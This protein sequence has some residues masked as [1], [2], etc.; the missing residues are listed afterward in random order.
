MTNKN[1]RKV[2]SLGIFI[3]AIFVLGRAVVLAF[4]APQFNP[5]DGSGALT[6]GTGVNAGNIGIGAASP[7]AK[8]HVSAPAGTDAFSIT[9][10]LPLI[11][12]Q[13]R[14]PIII[15]NTGGALVN[16]QVLLTIDTASLFAVGKMKFSDC[17]DLRVTSA[18]GVT[19]QNYWIESGC[20]TASTKIWAK[21]LAI[22]AGNS[23]IYLYYGNSGAA[24]VSNGSLTFPLFFDDFNV[25]PGMPTWS[26]PVPG[27]VSVSGGILTIDSSN[28][29]QYAR[30]DSNATYNQDVAV[31][32]RA[33]FTAS[34]I[35]FAGLVN[36]PG[37]QYFT[38]FQP[39]L[40]GCS[41]TVARSY[42]GTNNQTTLSDVGSAYKVYEIDR[43][44]LGG[45]TP[46]TYYNIDDVLQISHNTSVPDISMSIRL[47]DQTNVI[48]ANSIKADWILVRSYAN[49]EPTMGAIGA[50]EPAPMFLINSSGNVGINVAAP[51]AKLDVGGSA[52]FS[53][54]LI[55]A[56]LCLSGACRS[57]WPTGP[58]TWIFG[59]MYSIYWGTI[60]CQGTPDYA[61]SSVNP[62]TG[63]RSCPAGFNAPVALSCA[64]GSYDNLLNPQYWGTRLYFCYK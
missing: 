27:G 45:V 8:L 35:L 58:G 15:S 34:G 12:W 53:G 2:F 42:N 5:P 55:G 20:N 30:I 24:A 4:N 51:V 49:P 14:K 37:G 61:R 25:M 11:G 32:F 26:V 23:T 1:L 3:V 10:T 6:L 18:D 64:Y 21:V 44:K 62:Y 19:L 41:N 47:M 52:N 43:F 48:N 36:L 9:A 46:Y 63:G 31:R 59:G 16:Y 50:E 28:V 56:Q 7:S 39:C 13:Y 54:Q 33:N 29:N 22:P 38:V 40:A 17:R 60:D 57:T